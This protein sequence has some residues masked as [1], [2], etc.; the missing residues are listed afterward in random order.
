[1]AKHRKARKP[2]ATYTMSR[3][4]MRWLV[5]CF[6]LVSAAGIWY[7]FGVTPLIASPIYW[8]ADLVGLPL[9]IIQVA[10]LVLLFQWGRQARRQASYW[11]YVDV[12]TG[13]SFTPVGERM[14]A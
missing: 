3:R 1:M 8:R 10:L 13:E 2:P 5:A 11:R 12:E 14:E 7:G 4:Q 6:L 9:T